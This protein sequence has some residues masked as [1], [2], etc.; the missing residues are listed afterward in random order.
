METNLFFGNLGDDNG[1]ITQASIAD[2]CDE[3]PEATEAFLQAGNNAAGCL[4]HFECGFQNIVKFVY[5]G[6]NITVTEGIL[7]AVLTNELCYAEQNGVILPVGGCN[8]ADPCETIVNGGGGG[9]DGLLG[10]GNSAR[11]I[12]F[13]RQILS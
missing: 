2:F 6:E 5:S 9:G 11:L 4:V 8:Y 13:R 3:G 7:Q 10:S 1:E 12:L